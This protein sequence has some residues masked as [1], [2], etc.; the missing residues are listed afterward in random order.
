LVRVTGELLAIGALLVV[1]LKNVA[2]VLLVPVWPEAPPMRVVKVPVIE[3]L[4]VAVAV[5]V[6]ELEVL[7]LVLGTLMV[8]ELQ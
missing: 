8:V 2:E 5:D 6:V 4:L 3:V 1:A 7:V